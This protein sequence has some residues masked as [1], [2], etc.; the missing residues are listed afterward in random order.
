LAKSPRDLFGGQAA[1]HPQRQRRAGLA[2]QQWMTGGEDQAQQFV[3]DVVV[4]A[5]I[6]I[7]HGILLLLEVAGDHLMLAR[8]H[9]VAAQMIQRPPLGG[10]H[11]PGAGLFRHA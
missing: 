3:T 11:Q 1:D 9:P 5:P 6:Q 4:E 10:C 7:G 8:E 2:R